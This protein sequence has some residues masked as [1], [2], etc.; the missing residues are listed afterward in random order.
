LKQRRRLVLGVGVDWKSHVVGMHE[1]LDQRRIPHA[2]LPE[3]LVKHRW[4]TGWLGP[5]ADQLVDLATT[6]DLQ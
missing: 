3:L 4:D 6:P 1:L 5:V 2:Y